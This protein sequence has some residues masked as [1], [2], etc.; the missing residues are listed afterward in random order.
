[1][2]KTAFLFTIF[3]SLSFSC[4]A[5]DNDASSFDVYLPGVSQTK[6]LQLTGALTLQATSQ[7]PPYT[8]ISYIDYK[9]TLATTQKDILNLITEIGPFTSANYVTHVLETA[10]SYLQNVPYNGGQGEGDGCAKGRFKIGCMHIQQDL[11]YRTDELN[12]QTFVQ[13]TLALLNAKNLHTYISNIV[14]IDYGAEK[15]QGHIPEQII[16][17]S[18]RNNFPVA[19]FN[20]VNQKTGLLTDVTGEDVFVPLVHTIPAN[21]TR[22]NWF[23]FQYKPSAIATNVHVFAPNIGEMMAQKF[24]NN[25][26]NFYL[27]ETINAPYIPKEDLV[28]QTHRANGQND[29]KPNTD[30]INQIPTPSVVEVIR[31]DSKWFIGG[32]NIVDLIGSGLAASNMAFL[33]RTHFN[34]GDTVYQKTY[35]YLNSQGV[36]ECTVTPQVCNNAKGCT[37]TMML[38][39]TNAYPNGYLWVHN[40]VTNQYNCVAPNDIPKGSTMLTTCNRVTSMPF[41]DYITFQYNGQYIYINSPSIVGFNIQKINS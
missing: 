3:A 31:D 36:K 29:Y 35:C 26:G 7:T 23:A 8:I 15:N 11:L 13:L 25:Y 37:E 12:C 9:N 14:K 27:P 4:F 1:M 41:G 22:A 5:Q 19:D 17:Y 20:S 38:A 30:L 21:I 34:E 10:G 32:I 6:L 24:S 39:A 16:S 18:N 33:Y 40:T 28:M 2:L